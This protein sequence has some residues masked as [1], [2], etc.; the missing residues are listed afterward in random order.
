MCASRRAQPTRGTRVPTEARNALSRK[1]TP[2]KKIYSRMTH[3]ATSVYEP[4]H[5][6]K[7]YMMGVAK[8][9]ISGIRRMCAKDAER[10]PSRTRILALCFF[11]K[12]QSGFISRRSQRTHSRSVPDRR[13]RRKARPLRGP[14]GRQT[15][16]NGLDLSW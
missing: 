9:V 7:Q 1:R 10:G 4:R 11:H 2:L 13:R 8:S 14:T 6:I 12:H 16:R 3:A 5:R 15:S